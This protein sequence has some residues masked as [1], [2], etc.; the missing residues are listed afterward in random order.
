[1]SCGSSTDQ[2]VFVRP[3]CASSRY[4]GIA[5]ITPGTSTPMSS[6]LNTTPLPGNTYFASA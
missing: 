1:M 5:T 3:T 4:C 6:T 2:Y